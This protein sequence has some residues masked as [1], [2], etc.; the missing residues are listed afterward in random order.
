EAIAKRYLAFIRDSFFIPL[1]REI[2][3]AAGLDEGEPVQEAEIECV[4]GLHG[5]IGYVGLRRWVFKTPVMEDMDTVVTAL[6]TTFV[7]GAPAAFRT[8]DAARR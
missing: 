3:A 4:A 7:E 8:L 6:V 5:A 1:C 2:R